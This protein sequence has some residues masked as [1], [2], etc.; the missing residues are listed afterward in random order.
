[1][2][3]FFAATG[4]HIDIRAQEIFHLGPVPVTNSMMLGVI[5]MIITLWLLF[6]AARAVK[7]GR[8]GYVSGA[9]LMIYE[10]LSF[11]TLLST[12]GLAFCRL[13]GQSPK[14]AFLYSV[15]WWQT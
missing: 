11:S 4:P 13:L 3:Q 8:K 9:V 10:M 15:A 12:T 5:G 1:M 14:T 6:A 7:R 2:F